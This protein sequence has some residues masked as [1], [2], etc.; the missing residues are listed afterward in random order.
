[1]GVS[2][3]FS[4]DGQQ[5]YTDDGVGV[6]C[7]A[8]DGTLRSRHGTA[9]LTN[10]NIVPMINGHV[11]FRQHI[12]D[13]QWVSG[14]DV[15]D[16]ATGRRLR[17]IDPGDAVWYALADLAPRLA[18]ARVEGG[19]QVWDCATGAPIADVPVTGR[20]TRMALDP[21]GSALVAATVDDRLGAWIVADGWPLLDV[22][23]GALGVREVAIAPAGR[24]VAAALPDGTVAL[25]TPAVRPK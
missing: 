9:W 2:F 7:S 1:M 25:W 24:H 18:V 11:L 4:V 23:L 13:G 22:T 20:V 3:T 21:A 6:I 15:H 5:V 10:P 12:R 19:V 14:L 8:L 16:A 17:T